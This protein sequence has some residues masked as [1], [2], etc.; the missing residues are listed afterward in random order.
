MNAALRDSRGKMG[1][2]R[3]R[4]RLEQRWWNVLVASS[5]LR[6]DRQDLGRVGFK[7]KR[8][9]ATANPVLVGLRDRAASGDFVANPNN[10]YA[11]EKDEEGCENQPR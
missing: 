7:M 4:V 9:E 2:S 10:Q 5:A 1:G 8:A 6:A 11:C 3:S